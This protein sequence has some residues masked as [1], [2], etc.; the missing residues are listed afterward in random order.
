MIQAQK[1]IDGDK[2]AL[3][4]AIT[5]IESLLPEDQKAAEKIL[6]HISGHE[7]KSQTI[8]I[9]G[10]PG[11]GKSTFIESIG[12]RLI[13]KGKKIAVLAVDPSSPLNGGSILGDKTRM[14]KLARH[15]NAFVRPSPN[16]GHPG[17][18]SRTT[19]KS[20]QLC[21]AA[22]YDT[23]FVETVGVGQSEY[24][25]ASLVDVLLLLVLPNAGDEL[26]GIKRGIFEL[27]DLILVNKADGEHKIS[28]EQA[29]QN[30]ESALSL[31][32]SKAKIRTCSSLHFDA[33]FECVW[34]S[35][36]EVAIKPSQK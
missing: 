20:I 22:G 33:D 28:A 34:K 19:S 6:T 4:K 25:V 29:K 35:I 24:A 3:A 21:C 9:T 31:S 27:A 8:G 18:I 23:I 13:E 11:V 7:K 17:G 2:R 16:A 36:Q 10:V 12:S 5:L 26:Q 14:E 32:H 1:I 30:Y 15:P